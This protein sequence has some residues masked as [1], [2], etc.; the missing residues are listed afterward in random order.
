[1]ADTVRVRRTRGART[2][3]VTGD[4]SAGA[5]GPVEH[6]LAW[7]AVDAYAQLRG[8][9]EAFAIEIEKHIPIGGGLGG[10]SADAGAVLRGLDALSDAP[11]G[12]TALLQ[13]ARSLGADVPFL[14]TTD[15]YA[16]AWGRG[17]RMLALAPPPARPVMLLVPEFG[18]NTAEAYRWLAE[19]R[20]EGSSAHSASDMLRLRF[21]SDWDT[22]AAL[23][24]ND[25]E[26]PVAS[27][28]PELVGYAEELRAM[29]CVIAMMSGSGSTVFGV[30][31]SP[32]YEFPLRD[33]AFA[34]G[35]AV[36]YLKTRSVTQVEA[37]SV[38]E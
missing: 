8:L 4:V 7:R 17:E 20:S 19:S 28:H 30:G 6:N 31:S 16:L 11:I 32:D 14:T 24:T 12:E 33:H 26:P 5:L 35:G 13:I 38:I 29:G 1:L 27:R 10:G 25:F 9:D 21:L 15:P 3:D 23:A 37:V 18:V 36:R 22:V 2:L 34:A